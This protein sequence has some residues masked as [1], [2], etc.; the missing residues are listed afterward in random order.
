MCITHNSVLGT[1]AST[2][3]TQAANAV[4]PRSSW[5]GAKEVLPWHASE[6]FHESSGMDISGEADFFGI[7]HRNTQTWGGTGRF[8][9]LPGPSVPLAGEQ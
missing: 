7:V 2:Y 6:G 4:L 9:S 8:L 3:P 5:G 1:G